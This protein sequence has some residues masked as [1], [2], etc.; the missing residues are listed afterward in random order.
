MIKLLEKKFGIIDEELKELMENAPIEKIEEVALMIFDL[1]TI[2]QVKD[3][4]KGWY[5]TA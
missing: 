3:I 2:D 4:L 1:K 5:H